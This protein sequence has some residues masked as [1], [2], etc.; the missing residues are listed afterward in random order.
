MI[1]LLFL[2]PWP[3]VLSSWPSCTRLPSWTLEPSATSS[4]PC[5]RE[6]TFF[7]ASAFQLPSSGLCIMLDP[8]NAGDDT[9]APL[10]SCQKFQEIPASGSSE[11]L[12]VRTAQ[13]NGADPY[14][15]FATGPR[16]PHHKEASQLS[17]STANFKSPAFSLPATF[18]SKI[19]F[20]LV[21]SD[22]ST[23]LVN[24]LFNAGSDAIEVGSWYS[25]ANLLEAS[26]WDVTVMKGMTYNEFST[27][28]FESS[29]SNLKRRFNMNIS[30]GGCYS[31]RG[32][33]SISVHSS[34]GCPYDKTQGGVSYLYTVTNSGPERY[35]IKVFTAAEIRIY[36]V[37]A[38]SSTKLYARMP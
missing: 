14:T 28:G 36:G 38:V 20:Q 23:V 9:L 34:N 13:A 35:G 27:K 21:D 15:F 37:T 26:P 7:R 24:L 4:P 12:L 16:D 18:W 8:C 19:R 10:P 33:L 25:L 3:A 22:G 32:F 6:A 17:G 30:R 2:V 1:L 31:D 5:S 29:S 11:V